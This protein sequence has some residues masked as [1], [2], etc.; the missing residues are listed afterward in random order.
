MISVD[1]II[2]VEYCSY[3]DLDIITK[4][5]YRHSIWIT[6]FI[7]V[8]LFQVGGVLQKTGRVFTDVLPEKVSWKAGKASTQK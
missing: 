8:V 5:I 3:Y 7:T 4:L 2:K 6:E 1:N